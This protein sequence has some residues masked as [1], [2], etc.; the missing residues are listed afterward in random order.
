MI[1]L[2]IND[3][4]TQTQILGEATMQME[5][6]K[7]LN[8]TYL[9]NTSDQ[10]R[11]SL[12]KAVIE[13]ERLDTSSEMFDDI[14]SGLSR[15]NINHVIT[16]SISNTDIVLIKP[17]IPLP[18]SMKVFTVKDI[19]SPMIG[20]NYPLK[21]FI[22]VSELITEQDGIYRVNSIDRLIAYLVSAVF[23]LIYNIEPA[24]LINNTV[25]IMSIRKSFAQMVTY[26]I[27]YLYKI[28][29]IDGTKDMCRHL[30]AMY[31]D[32]NIL[33]RN[34]ETHSSN[35]NDCATKI[36]GL[37]NRQLDV[38]SIY[39]EEDSF[40]NIKTFVETLGR[41]LKLQKLT[42]DVFIGK[43]VY[44]YGTSTLFALEY[45]PA[46][47]DVFTN[48]YCLSYI[49]NQKTIEKVVDNELSNYSSRFISLAGGLLK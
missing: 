16:K 11:V 2:D 27:D 1:N 39:L 46:L 32:I 40:D 26:I 45:F 49:N 42:V 19:K 25:M 41:I 9:F 18:K 34:Y 5:F 23:Q 29:N 21:V 20:G 4:Q 13:S 36:S 24:R 10:Y 14:K 43:W 37:S 33:K 38:L 30:A 22:D 3:E 31:F 35:I 48:A 15:R 7:K 8:E 47:S 44:I 17:K 28:S 6:L 12:T